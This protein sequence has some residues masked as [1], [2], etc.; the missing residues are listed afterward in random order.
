MR[1]ST[2]P[3]RDDARGLAV[4]RAALDAGVTLLD[5]ADAYCL[6][7]SERGHNERL[8]AHAVAG[9]DVRVVTKGGLTRPGGAW[10]P[11]GKARH[12]VAAA[13]ASRERLGVDALDLYLLH[14]IDPR[15]ALATSVR[16]LARIRDDGV[17]RAIGLSNITLHQLE[18]AEQLARMDAVQVELSPWKLDAVRGG[19]VAACASRGIQLLAHRPLGGPAGVKRAAKDPVLRAIAERL[20]ATPCDVVLAWLRALSPVIVPL[21]GATRVETAQSAGRALILD[22]EALAQLRARFLAIGD[23]SRSTATRAG[24]IVLVTG[25]PG[26]GKSTL[27]EDFVAKGYLRLNRDERGGSLLDL[28]RELDAVLAGG[29][30]RVVLDNTY[31]TRASRAPVIE[32]AHRHGLAIRCV[33]LATALED[34]QGNAAA[35]V[36][37]QHGR[38]LEPAELRNGTIGPGAQFRFRRS[39]EPP[40]TDEGFT[41]VEEV[42]FTP[43]PRTGSRPALLVELDDA[44][45]VGRPR[46]VDKVRLHASAAPALAAW[47]AAGHVLA[48]T[49]WQPGVPREQFATLVARLEELLGLTLVTACCTHAPGPPVCWCRKPLPGLAL[50]LAR[51]HDLA[52][53]RMLCVG[54]GAAD[55]GFARRARIRYHD[56]ATGWPIPDQLGL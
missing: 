45:W 23:T 8:I 49:S 36:L 19:L 56:L 9:R 6:D 17:A 55:K 15:T 16:A 54:R 44:V 2:E 5:T 51:E 47:H 25:M 50:A 31:G 33:V 32:L 35:R 38:L 7:D 26:A 42:A 20:A 3:D 29:A 39:Y 24:E 18:A 14:A 10:V 53:D 52:L 40:R 22:D 41:T 13:R 4:L 21:P 27:A 1:L 12:L 11:D 37:A 43:H 28:A 30:D 46:T 34:A 48:A